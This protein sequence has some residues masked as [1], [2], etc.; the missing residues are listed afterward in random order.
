MMAAERQRPEDRD[1]GLRPLERLYRFL[2]KLVR[3][4]FFGRV[5][6]SFQ[7]G[8]LCDIKIEQTKKMDEL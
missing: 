4:A 1:S 7:N 3:S 5:T 6:L 8:R 2:D